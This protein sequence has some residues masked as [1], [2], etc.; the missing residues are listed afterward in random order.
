MM[1]SF[2]YATC[3]LIGRER[4]GVLFRAAAS[5]PAVASTLAQLD[6]AFGLD[7]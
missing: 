5:T 6:T 3:T 7:R 1:A 2:S 4:E